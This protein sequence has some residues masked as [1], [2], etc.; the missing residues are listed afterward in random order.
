MT[1]YCGIDWA[2]NHHDIAFVDDSGQQIARRR[3]PDT[4]D[5]LGAS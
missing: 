4:A 5:G 1:V 2:E 3:I